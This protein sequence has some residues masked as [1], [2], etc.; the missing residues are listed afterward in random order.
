MKIRLGRILG[1]LAIAITEVLLLSVASA[2]IPS[3]NIWTNIAIAHAQESSQYGYRSR[4]SSF[5]SGLPPFPKGFIALR[6][7]DVGRHWTS[8]QLTDIIAFSFRPAWSELEP[9][10][11]SYQWSTVISFIK[12]AVDQYHKKV[13]L[14][15]RAGVNSPTWIYN[16][17]YSVPKFYFEMGKIHAHGE[18]EFGQAVMPVPWNPTYLD[19]NERMLKALAATIKAMGTSPV[20]GRPYWDAVFMVHVVG[21]TRADAEMTLPRKDSGAPDNRTNPTQGFFGGVHNYR[22]EWHAVGYTPETVYQ[23]W[24]R[25]INFYATLFPDKYLAFDTMSVY[26][27]KNEY[28]QGR[29]YRGGIID[30]IIDYAVA[31]YPGRV[32]LQADNLN[33]RTTFRHDYQDIIAFHHQRD[34]VIVGFS[35]EIPS[36]RKALGGSFRQLVDN[37]LSFGASYIEVFKP[38]ILQFPDDLRYATNY[39]ATH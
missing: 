22:K 8:A 18:R 15:V 24:V 19:L 27:F 9:S 35:T 38:D 30:A 20:T 34:H 12:T 31:T 21:P 36:K 16:P 39:W 6:L 32:T 29:L 11:N 3:G 5:S 1:S 14:D 2:L 26:L 4:P 7:D 17:P 33:P 10:P 37:G 13:T 23:A 25:T 28:L